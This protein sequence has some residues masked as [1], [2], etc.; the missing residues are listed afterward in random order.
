MSKSIAKNS[1]YNIV[2]KCLNVLFPLITAAYVSRVL[3]AEGVGKVSGAQNIVQYFFLVAALGLPT[4]GVKAIASTERNREALSKT[5]SELFWINACST[6]ICTIL[7]YTMIFALP[8]F[9][10][11]TLLFVISGLKIPFNFINIDWF[12]QGREEYRYIMLRSMMIKIGLFAAVFLFVKTQEDYCI[13]ALLLVLAT[14]TNYI[15]NIIHSKKYADIVTKGLDL[16]SHIKL[17]MA[18]LAASISIEIYTLADTTMLT[19]IKGDTIVGYYSQAVKGINVIKTLVTAICAVF[20]PRL[21]YYHSI[22]EKKKFF[23]LINKGFKILAFISIPTTLGTI[24]V[25]SDMVPVLFGLGFNDSI[26]TVQILSVSIISC[27]FSNFIGYQILVTLGKERQ[28]L[29]STVVGACTNIFL[30]AVLIGI[31]SHNG[32]AIASVITEILVTVIQAF[33]IRH[34]VPLHIE[35]RFVISLIFSNIGMM[36]CVFVINQIIPIRI[37]RMMSAVIVGVIA[38]FA[39]SIGLKND[40]AKKFLSTG[41]RLLRRRK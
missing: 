24:L 29:L 10:G 5:F 40:I 14:G 28:M 6:L 3:L 35:K 21:S 33:V 39:I 12:Y 8:Y 11:R 18:L 1:L 20:L 15:F 2:Y 32:A 30:N 17:V 25:A 38:Y 26:L 31:W 37:I 36:V 34:V 27:A 23:D 4:Y 9:E 13:Y 19:F 22:G 41:L 16:K 7:Y